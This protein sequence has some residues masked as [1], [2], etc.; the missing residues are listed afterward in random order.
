MPINKEVSY[1]VSGG[2][3]AGGRMPIDADHIVG[4]GDPPSWIDGGCQEIDGADAL[5]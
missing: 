3:A 1:R 5:S 2:T 4:K